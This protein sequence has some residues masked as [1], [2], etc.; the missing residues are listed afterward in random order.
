M[1]P[2]IAAAQAELASRILAKRRLITFTQR[3]NPR[4]DAA[5]DRSQTQDVAADWEARG[6]A[7]YALSAH[8]IAESDRRHAAKRYD[9]PVA[10]DRRSPG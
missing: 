9:L 7:N 1:P 8:R 10:Q 3:I 5:Y 4:Y 2:K 6:Y